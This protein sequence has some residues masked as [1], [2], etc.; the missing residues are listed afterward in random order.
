[1]DVLDLDPRTMLVAGIGA[2]V[3]GSPEA[4][5]NVGR[6]LGWVAGNAWRITGPVV[7]PLVDAGRDVASQV[8]D[9]AASNGAGMSSPSAPEARAPR[10]RRTAGA[11]S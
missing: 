9:S 7:M 2:A 4:R 11:E 3:I 6:G 8:R 10:T 1:M 5:R